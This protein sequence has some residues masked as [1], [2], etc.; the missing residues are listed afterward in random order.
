MRALAFGCGRWSGDSRQ[1]RPTSESGC[2]GKARDKDNDRMSVSDDEEFN[3]PI[4]CTWTRRLRRKMSLAERAQ[5]TRRESELKD[6]GSYLSELVIA[7]GG[8]R[9]PEDAHQQKLESPSNLVCWDD[10]CPFD[11]NMPFRPPSTC[12][13]HSLL[14]RISDQLCLPFRL[15]RLLG[16]LRDGTDVKNILCDHRIRAGQLSHSSFCGCE[17]HCAS[18]LNT[19]NVH[20]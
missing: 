11:S 2:F 9:P 4:D 15:A 18:S 19:V 14:I 12:H 6:S 5:G 10:F 1:R 3:K 20:S 8:L 16:T 13:R 7:A 17:L